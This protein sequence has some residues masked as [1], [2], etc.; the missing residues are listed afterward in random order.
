MESIFEVLKAQTLQLLDVIPALIKAVIIFLV[1]WLL[2]KIIS[3]IIKR[4]LS[5]IGVDKLAE[6]LMSIDIFQKSNINLVPSKIAAAGVYYFIIIIFAMSAI[7]ALGMQMISD[8]M[9]DFIAFIPNGITAFVVLMLGI[10]LSDAI[11]KIIIT[12][13][14]SLGITSGNLIGN[15]VFYFLLLN[16]VLIALRQ[17]QLQTRFMETNI[18][19]MLAGI[20]GAFAIGYGMA[21]RHLMGSLLAGFYNRGKMKVGDEVTIDG[22]RGEI[23]TINNNDLI[24][25]AEDSEYIVPFSKV[26]SAGVEIHTRR[27]AGLA[28]P[29]HEGT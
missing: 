13:C 15:V 29:P 6:K 2:A 22:M 3:R 14:K 11:K 24:L 27:D 8:L 7:Q 26:S 18:S 23:V 10:F 19:I 28:L 21:S 9:S 4:A 1:G 20:A 17:A 16:I 25:R 12:T 5:T